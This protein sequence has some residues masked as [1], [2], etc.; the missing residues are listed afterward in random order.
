MK[1]RA[2]LVAG[3]MGLF[4]A[5]AWAGDD[6]TVPA[7]AENTLLD[8]A[9]APYVL[10]RRDIDAIE[11]AAVKNEKAIRDAHNRL[12]SYEPE[13][14][15]RAYI[16]YAALVAADSP[17]FAAAIES[18]TRRDKN[19]EE[20]LIQLRDNPA[21]VRDL[22]GADE[23][24][25][26]I[27]AM[28]ARDATRIGALGELYIQEAYVLQEQAWARKK[29]AQD[30]MSRVRGAVTWADSRAWPLLPPRPVILSKSGTT[31]PNLVS[32]PTWS[33]VWSNLDAVAVPDEHSGATMTRALLLGARYAVGDLTEGQLNG[34]AIS[35]TQSK[36]FV[37]AKLNLDQCIA[38]TR[39]PYEEAF[40]I[41]THGLQDISQC[42]GWPAGA[43][44]GG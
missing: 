22:E 30:G 13:E 16:A 29:L 35:K 28:T 15:G 8:N 4:A 12:A 24:I 33:D 7:V 32:D 44:S 23:A 1:R 6:E 9:A 5:M 34:Y 20:F 25:N 31:R 38:A 36:C 41:G 3:A 27:M 17:T 14:M 26:A 18:K 19:R 43:G 21:T 39:T 42:V 37:N 10:L 11:T 2:T 40:C